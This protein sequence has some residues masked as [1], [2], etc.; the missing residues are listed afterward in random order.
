MDGSDS[1]ER[2]IILRE[3]AVGVRLDAYLL[4]KSSVLF[5]LAAVQCVLL[6]GVATLI[7]PLH[8]YPS[9]YL[10]LTGLLILTSWSM[11]GVGLV[12]SSL[13]RSV[14]QASSLIPLLLIPQLL[15]GA[16]LVPFSRMGTVIKGLADMLVTRWAFAGAGHAIHMNARLAEAPQVTAI[17]GYGLNFF[18]LNGAVAAIILLGFTAATLLAVAILLARQSG[19]VA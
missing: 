5:L 6:V 12:V 17:S 1:T 13:A 16:A 19:Q 7:Q 8:A 2:S 18:S 3:L 10:E 15:F 11:V 4:A 9:V 14:D